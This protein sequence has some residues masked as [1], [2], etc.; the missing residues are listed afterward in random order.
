[1]K[2]IKAPGFSFHTEP[3]W[4]LMGSAVPAIIGILIVLLVTLLRKFVL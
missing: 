2:K 3:V 4:M 1:M